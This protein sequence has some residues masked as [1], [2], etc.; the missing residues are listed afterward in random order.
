[1]IDTVAASSK[2]VIALRSLK[3]T[4]RGTDRAMRV[5]RLFTPDAE[6]GGICSDTAQALSREPA[7]ANRIAYA[8]TK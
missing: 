3:L 8:F 4:R 6:M 2:M 7:S 1:L 5:L